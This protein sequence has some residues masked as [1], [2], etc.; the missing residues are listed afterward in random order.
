MP[1]SFRHNVDE[2]PHRVHCKRSIYSI[3]YCV[4]VLACESVSAEVRSRTTIG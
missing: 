3:I 1:H 4:C 2:A